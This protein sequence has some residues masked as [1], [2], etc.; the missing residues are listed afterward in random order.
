MGEE[1]SK[2]MSKL[3]EKLKYFNLPFSTR[4]P[5]GREKTKYGKTYVHKLTAHSGMS[6]TA[7]QEELL[8]RKQRVFR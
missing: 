8:N 6:E 4:D 7:L 5:D 1:G 2:G 3:N